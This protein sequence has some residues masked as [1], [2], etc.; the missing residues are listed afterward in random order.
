VGQ[1]TDDRTV[2]IERLQRHDDVEL[3]QHPAGPG[4]LAAAQERSDRLSERVGGA[5]VRGPLLLDGG[6]GWVE[7]PERIQRCGQRLPLF[8]GQKAV[9]IPHAVVAA[10]QGCATSTMRPAL[11]RLQAGPVGLLFAPPDLPGQLV[12][13]LTARERE[14]LF[15][16]GTRIPE[17]TTPGAAAD[18]LRLLRA[19]LPRG[20]RVT[21]TGQ[22]P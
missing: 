22:T 12:R 20:Q 13:A 19:D 1:L 15:L 21:G 10:C 17:H 6:A 9:E 4:A 3:R 16:S 18:R 8:I 11:S 7:G 14:Q 5:L 2:G